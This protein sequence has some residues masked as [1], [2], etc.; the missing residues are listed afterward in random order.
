MY[1][2]VLLPLKL[3][4]IPLYHSQAELRIGQRVQVAFAHREYMGII[5]MEAA[6]THDIQGKVILDITQTYGDEVPDVSANELKFW[7]FISQYYLCTLGQVY[8]AAYPKYKRDSELPPKRKR[9]IIP[10]PE[11]LRFDSEVDA[12]TDMTK[13]MLYIGK[14]ASQYYIPYI[15]RTLQKGQTVLVLVPELGFAQGFV[16]GFKSRYGQNMLVY[17]SSS[18]SGEKRKALLGARDRTPLL[19]VGGRS[20]LF[21]PF[22]N[23][24]LII[25]DQEQDPSYKQFEPAPRYNARDM[26]A[27]LASIHGADLLFGC[28][29]PSLE[30]WYNCMT[31]KFQLTRSSDCNNLTD[32]VM[33]EIPAEKRKRGMQGEF[34]AKAFEAIRR[35]D[36]VVRII[37]SYTSEE[38]VSSAI[39]AV[40]PDR[41]FVVQ[42]FQAA[43]KDSA[44][45]AMTLVL[46]AEAAFDKDDFRSD[47]HALQVLRLIAEHSQKLV[48]QCESANRP[49][50]RAVNDISFLNQLLEERRTFGFPPFGR[51]VNILDPKTGTVVK[52]VIL[53]K[54]QTLSEQKRKLQLQYGS[55]YTIDVDPQ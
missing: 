29:T 34:S 22:S 14:N 41:E 2:Y 6:Q 1:Y 16:E 23:L 43:K 19:I 47:E 36:G 35:T 48:V 33:V 49:L 13:P 17:S 46:N 39:G 40:F 30:S 32:L 37:R 31:G 54:D 53:T 55:L 51:L 11:P 44:D 12:A 25:V 18:T 38:E 20:A 24:G 7:E 3:D 4:W 10:L 5:Y 50:Y 15:D 27:V 21:L 26:A 9:K 28:I 52:Q 45:Y 8:A 42:T